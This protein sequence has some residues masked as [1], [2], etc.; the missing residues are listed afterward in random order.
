MLLGHPDKSDE[1]KINLHD[2]ALEFMKSM[3]LKHLVDFLL[4]DDG[5]GQI[6][7]I[8]DFEIEDDYRCYIPPLSF[9]EDYFSPKKTSAHG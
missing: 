9:T 6:E 8:S 1:T 3:N 4:Q 5:H 2:D 7:E